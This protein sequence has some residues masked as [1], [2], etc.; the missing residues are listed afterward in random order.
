[1][2][3]IDLS[4]DLPTGVEPDIMLCANNK[5]DTHEVYIDQ[6]LKTK[7]LMQYIGLLVQTGLERIIIAKCDCPAC[8]QATIDLTAMKGILLKTVTTVP[9]S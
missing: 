1:M 7:E 4:L 9:L 8:K 6:T 3:Q 5:D 2:R